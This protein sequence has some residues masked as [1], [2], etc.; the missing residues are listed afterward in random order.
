MTLILEN[1]DGSQNARVAR[2]WNFQCRPFEAVFKLRISLGNTEFRIPEMDLEIISRRQLSE[3]I[4]QEIC[5]FLDSHDT[6]HPFQF[7]QWMPP[8]A[9]EI[10]F[11]LARVNSKLAAF[12][13]CGLQRPAGTRVPVKALV[14]NRGP[15]C[16]DFEKFR[17][18]LTQ[19]APIAKARKLI[20]I[21]AAPERV[22]SDDEKS[23]FPAPWSPTGAERVSLRLDVTRSEDEI[24]AGFRKVARY[25]IR[26][27]E[28]AGIQVATAS[29]DKD[30]ERFLNLY[31]RLAKRKGFAADSPESVGAILK[32]LRAEPERGGLFLAWHQDVAVGGVVTVRASQRCWYVWGASEERRDFSAGHVLQWHAIRW[33]KSQGCTEYDFGG[34]TPGAKSGPAWFKEG[35]GGKVMRLQPTHRL[36]LR[37][38]QYRMLNLARSLKGKLQRVT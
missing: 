10:W 15:V 35:F 36:V 5:A 19:L 2:L 21:D 11:V 26:R 32:W 8:A 29:S 7:P 34:Y 37:D 38:T 9:T 23:L 17:E 20:Y 18:V 6:S 1:Y 3:T 16:D 24:F 13:S 4:V 31:F 30:S 12:A 28:R 33:A 25:E 27:A 14:I 22:I